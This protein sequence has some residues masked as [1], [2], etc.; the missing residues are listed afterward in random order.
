[1]GKGEGTTAS[2]VTAR[3]KLNSPTHHSVCTVGIIVRP[4]ATRL[5]KPRSSLRT[6]EC[7]TRNK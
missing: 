6:L 4:L 1:M 3:E 5:P 2:R 7:L